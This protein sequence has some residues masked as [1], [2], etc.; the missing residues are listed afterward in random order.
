MRDAGEECIADELSNL[1]LQVQQEENRP[2]A[3]SCLMCPFQECLVVLP[4][5]G[6][7]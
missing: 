3:V 1:R 4:V 5:H 2:T 6:F 7:P